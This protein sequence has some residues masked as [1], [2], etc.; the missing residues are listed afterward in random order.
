MCS[1][2]NI[3]SVSISDKFSL[4]N[5]K[6]FSMFSKRLSYRVDWCSFPLLTMQMPIYFNILYRYKFSN[7]VR[8]FVSTILMQRLLFYY[9]LL[10]I[11]ISSLVVIKTAM[12][13]MALITQHCWVNSWTWWSLRSL[14]TQPVLPFYA[15]S[16]AQVSRSRI[17]E[18]S[19][20]TYSREITEDE[21]SRESGIV[22]LDRGHS[23]SCLLPDVL[24]CLCSSMH[25]DMQE[26]ASI[27]TKPTDMIMWGG[28]RTILFFPQSLFNRVGLP[29]VRIWT[30]VFHYILV[31]VILTQNIRCL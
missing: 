27:T 13:C 23:Y 12:S 3:D 20:Q 22:L 24:V 19:A 21:H 31:L 25:L 5:H 11:L 7:Q 4:L 28:Q 16:M 18:A 29:K 8:T 17:T 10:R 6:F 2:L 9:G 1:I 14:P 30:F 26:K 15:P